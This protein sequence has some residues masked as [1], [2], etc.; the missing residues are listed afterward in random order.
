MKKP[1]KAGFL[2]GADSALLNIESVCRVGGS[3]PCGIRVCVNA[4]LL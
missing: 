1:A 2:F 4:L 3:K